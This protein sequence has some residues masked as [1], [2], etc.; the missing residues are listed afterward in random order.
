MS[1][2]SADI[3]LIVLIDG[4]LK[5]LLPEPERAVIMQAINN[6]H[7]SYFLPYLIKRSR[8]KQH[9]QGQLIHSFFVIYMI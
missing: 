3:K 5:M 6:T 1:S 7:L 9:T 2:I 4:N 8:N